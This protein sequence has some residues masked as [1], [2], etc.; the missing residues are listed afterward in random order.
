MTL[1]APTGSVDVSVLVP[2][3]DEAENLPE[4]LAQCEAAFRDAPFRA[5]VVVVDD[6]STDE[7]PQVLAA[8]A[9]RYPFLRHERHRSRQG[10]A[11]A[12]RTAG[13][14][15]RGAVLVFYPADLQFLPGEI[16]SLVA[17]VLAGEADLVTGAKQGVYEKA[18]VSGVYNRLCRRLFGLNVT[19]LN[20]V[21]AYRREIMESVPFRPDWHRF[22]AVVAGANGFRLAERPVTLH[23]RRAGR[24]K[25]GLSRIPV[26]VTDLLA[27]WFLLKFGRKPMLFFDVSGAVLF[28]LG[29]LSGVAALVVRFGFGV[30]F[31]PFLNLIETLVI[32]GIA[33]FGFGFIGEILASQREEMR[34]LHRTVAELAADRA[35]DRSD[36]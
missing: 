5:E 30:G 24:T 4:F 25:F 34:E 35:R 12:L 6:G 13:L 19:D 32:S 36:R 23:P 22:F 18:F 16:P 8:L 7:T 33:L 17:P 15:S 3:K 14:A 11:E 2:A 26:G 28:T 1:A 31:R 27:V 29:F 10:I 9:V 21:K 20:S